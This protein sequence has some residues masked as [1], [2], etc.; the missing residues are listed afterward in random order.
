M[1]HVACA[2]VLYVLA[3]AAPACAEAPDC[4]PRKPCTMDNWRDLGRMQSHTGGQAYA[5]A[6]VDVGRKSIFKPDEN[7]E[8]IAHGWLL[9]ETSYDSGR[10]LVSAESVTGTLNCRQRTFDRDPINTYYG[11]DGHFLFH[12]NYDKTVRYMDP[13]KPNTIEERIYAALCS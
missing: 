9:Y 12:E 10:G 11:E 4:S 7:G 13:I 1:R 2:A 3:S 8:V 6:Y 5:E